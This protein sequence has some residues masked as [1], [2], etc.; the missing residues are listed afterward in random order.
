[1]KRPSGISDDRHAWPE[2]AGAHGRE[3]YR[4]DRNSVDAQLLRLE[5]IQQLAQRE[6][7]RGLHPPSVKMHDFLNALASAK[8]NMQLG[9]DGVVV[10]MVRCLSWR[11]YTGGLERGDSRGHTQEHKIVFQATRYI[12]LLAVLQKFYVRVMQCEARADAMRRTSW[13]SSWRGARLESR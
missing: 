13:V 1:M 4:D 6:L 9:E 8:A 10:E 11:A 3:V 2:A 5:R 12:S 7:A